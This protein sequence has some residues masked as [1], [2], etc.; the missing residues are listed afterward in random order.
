MAF[1][2]NKMVEWV[3]GNGNF[4]PAIVTAQYPSSSVP[5]HS[6][7]MHD[8]VVFTNFPEDPGGTKQVLGVVEDISDPPAPGTIH[9]AGP[10]DN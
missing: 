2:K 9:A 1:R 4:W 6:V 10:E 5:G 8:V 7:S 3:D